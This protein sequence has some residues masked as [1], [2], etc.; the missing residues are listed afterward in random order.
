MPNP[1]HS[2]VHVST[3]L[4]NISIARFNVN[5]GKYRARTVFP[6]V[7]VMKQSDKYYT[8]NAD[9]LRRSQAERRAPGAEAEVGGYK[10]STDSYFADRWALARDIDD[11]TRENADPQFNLDAEAAEFLTDQ[12]ELALENE[13]TADFF[14]TATWNG[15]SGGSGVDQT[16]VSGAP[17][18]NQFLQWNDAA[19]TPIED[20][21]AEC[22]AVDSAT[23][24]RPNVLTIGPRVWASLADHPDLLDRIKHTQTG[25]VSTSLLAN[26]LEL[27]NVVVLGAVINSGNEG[28]T[29]SVDY[30]AGKHALLTYSAPSPGLRTATA[31]Y[32]FIWTAGGRPVGGA[33]MK[34]YRLERNESDR[35]EGEV[36]ADFKQVSA[37]LGA[38]FASAVA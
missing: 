18:A 3:P 23:G 31:G 5:R 1:T 20:I 35:I 24:L 15:G 26:V 29:A 27:G 2:A 4:T 17:A 8:Y 6:A 30:I 21:R 16:G 7:G 13:W 10:V 33:R 11:P 34:R 25:V 14:T 38:F 32:T 12:I 36:W 37:D 28:A 19:S 9:D 22:V